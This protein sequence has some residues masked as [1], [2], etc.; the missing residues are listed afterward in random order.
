MKNYNPSSCPGQLYPKASNPTA[1]S[2]KRRRGGTQRVFWNCAGERCR[3]PCR[4]LLPH[5]QNANQ[6]T[7]HASTRPFPGIVHWPT[8]RKNRSKTHKK[9]SEQTPRTLP[10]RI[11]PTTSFSAALRSISNSS[12]QQKLLARAANP[13]ALIALLT[14]PVPLK[15]SRNKDLD[16]RRAARRAD[17]NANFKFLIAVRSSTIEARRV[18][19]A[20]PPAAGALVR[21]Q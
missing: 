15:I 12:P 21:V 7:K 2:E 5:C 19:R 17:L 18:V 16:T 3:Q 14:E 1:G 8:G 10:F 20:R 9:L 6:A 13:W 11:H 4:I